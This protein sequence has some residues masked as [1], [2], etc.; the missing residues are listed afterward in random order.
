M[1]KE[2]EI[3][4]IIP[5]RGGSRSLPR[6]NAKLLCGK[7]LITYT[8]EAALN[9]RYIDRVIVSTEDKE[10]VEISGEYS[11]E[12][13]ERPLNLAQSDT[14][15][16]SVLQ[17][18]VKH[19][20]RVENFRPGILVILQPTSP[21]RTVKDIDGA[22]EKF[23]NTDCD[24]VVSVCRVEQPLQWMYI[25]EG[26]RLKSTIESGEEITRRQ[27]APEVYRLNGAVYVTRR[28]VIIRQGKLIS[29]D[30]RAYIMPL[31]R[32]VD[33][34]NELDFKFAE[35]LMKERGGQ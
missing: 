34:D 9:S 30:A 15:S 23:L 29:N 22:V 13:I 4:A 24:S 12:V 11:A 27:D 25:L 5:A 2:S 21:L 32:S 35:L 3:V 8:I 26:D 28:D 31:D 19:L 20:E 6:K 10:I 33:I 1:I 7:P 17:Q 18:V 16:F 14:P